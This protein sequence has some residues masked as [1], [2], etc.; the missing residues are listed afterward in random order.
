MIPDMNLDMTV[1]YDSLFSMFIPDT[2]LNFASFKLLVVK[3]S[4]DSLIQ[5]ELSAK[6]IKFKSLNG[7][8]TLISINGE[9]GSLSCNIKS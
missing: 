9:P 8:G 3:K 6:R 2:V 4:S 7:Y 5:A 1:Q